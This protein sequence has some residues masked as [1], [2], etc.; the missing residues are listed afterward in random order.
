MRLRNL[1]PSIKVAFISEHTC[2]WVVVQALA[3]RPKEAIGALG[4]VEF[5]VHFR[6]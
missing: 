6:W 1:L 5:I 3:I 2:T 4:L